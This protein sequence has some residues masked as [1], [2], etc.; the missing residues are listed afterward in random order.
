MLSNPLF[1][2]GAKTEEVA[3]RVESDRRGNSQELEKTFALICI[4]LEISLQIMKI[5]NYMAI[6]P[7]N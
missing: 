7:Q 3:T 6:Y 2:G 4:K 1:F 5:S